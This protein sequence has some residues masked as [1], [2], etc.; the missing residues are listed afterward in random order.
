MMKRLL[1]L[2]AATAAYAAANEISN[3]CSQV[4]RH[5]ATAVQKQVERYRQG[6]CPFADVLK[7]EESY[8]L[9]SM[10][11]ASNGDFI[12]FGRQLISNYKAQIHLAELLSDEESALQIQQKLY[13]LEARVLMAE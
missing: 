2:M 7:A 6:F 9:R 3:H 8:L 10:Q 11:G 12:R 1:F 4:M 13:A 5:P